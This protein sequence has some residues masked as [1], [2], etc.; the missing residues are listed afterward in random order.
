[1]N[2]YVQLRPSGLI[3]PLHVLDRHFSITS[4][5]RTSAQQYVAPQNAVSEPED[6]PGTISA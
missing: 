1:M 5:L 3:A 6:G 4:G 2:V